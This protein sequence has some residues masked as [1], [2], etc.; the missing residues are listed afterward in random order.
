MYVH[1]VDH[2]GR[3]QH[4]CHQIDLNHL[5]HSYSHENGPHPTEKIFQIWKKLVPGLFI[6]ER[7]KHQHHTVTKQKF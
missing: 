4:L 1:H 3:N 6:R 7:L 5:A 2:H